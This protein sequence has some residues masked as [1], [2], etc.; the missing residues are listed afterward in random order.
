MHRNFLSVNMFAAVQLSLYIINDD[1][2][3]YQLETLNY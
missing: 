2:N 3:D 1:V